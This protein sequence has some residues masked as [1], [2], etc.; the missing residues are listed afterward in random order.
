MSRR[1]DNRLSSAISV[2]EGMLLTN[3]S[4]EN[5]IEKSLTQLMVLLECEFGY[6]YRCHDMAGTRIPW[7]LTTSYRLQQGILEIQNCSSASSA[8]PETHQSMLISGKYLWDDNCSINEIPIPNPHPE[9]SN[10]L[11]VPIVDAKCIH[12]VV[13]LCN[14]LTGFDADIENRIRPLI[15]AAS[16]LLRSCSKTTH[17]QKT[18]RIDP[19]IDT[20]FELL[21]VF[22]NF[23]NSVI[24]VDGNNNILTCNQAAS[25]MFGLLRRDLLTKSIDQFLPKGIPKIDGRLQGGNFSNS[26]E[27][28]NLNRV[29]RGVPVITNANKKILVDLRAFELKHGNETLKGLVMDD[30]SERMKSAT[31]YQSILQRFE[32]LTNLAPVGILQVNRHWECTYAN[33]KWCEFSQMSPE[34]A[35]E[36]GWLNAIHTTDVDS[37]LDKLR[38]DTAL[39][40]AYQG[41]FRLQTPLGRVTWVEANAQSLY[42]ETGETTGLIMTFSD[43]TD[44][45]KN[46]RRLQDIA[47]KD[48][49]TGLVNRAFFHD[50]MENALKGVSRYGSV[51]LMF[52]DLDEFKHIND[53]LGHDVGDMLLREVAN[54]LREA[55]RNADTI[56]RIGG[57]EFTVILTNMDNPRS[58]N[59]VADKLIETLADPFII[60]DRPIYVTCTIGISVADT[61]ETEMSVLM[62]QAD[63]AL[64]KAKEAG[65]NQYKFYTSEL[66]KDANFHVHL[67]Q[68]LKDPKRDD[69]RLVFQPQ[70]NAAF[71]DIVGVEALCRWSRDDVEETG[72]DKFIKMI[73]ESGLINNFSDWLFQSIFSTMNSWNR[74]LSSPMSL[75]V[76]INLSAKQF[77]DKELAFHIFKYCG[78]YKVNPQSVVFEVTETALIDD[79]ELASKTLGKLKRMG[80]GLALDDFGTGYSSLAYLRKMPLDTLKIDHSFIKDVLSEEEDAQIVEAIINL[81]A[82]LKLNVIAEGVDN[83][84]VKEWLLRRNCCFHQGFYYH[85]PLEK[86]V[87]EELLN[88]K[89]CS[90]NIVEI[91]QNVGS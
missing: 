86:D 83:A 85:K 34:E 55:L 3:P 58:I 39:T 77:R 6:A 65:R 28:P 21:G 36:K 26:Q 12:G 78:L 2:I 18:T 80:F 61:E 10:F 60:G 47:E 59:I 19:A 71:G 91:T 82:T 32:L 89:P 49:L 74:Y 8:I 7:D 31:D 1:T 52:I 4:S 87:F 53:T 68:S 17:S 16:C 48:Q 24:L 30:I 67:R 54:R 15:A 22:D 81:A 27:K 20:H 64:Y 56:A 41:E 72:P 51:V 42:S 38:N 66:D 46:E 69:F 62:K 14:K 35:E 23:F 70:V 37:I 33:D 76:S 11:C 44:H 13:F 43:V 90:R 75:K 79:P 57:D 50:R 25:S 29:W 84:D 63:V 9:I 5:V 40:G 45:L 73:E 88:S